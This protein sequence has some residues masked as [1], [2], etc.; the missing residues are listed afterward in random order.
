M[1]EPSSAPRTAASRGVVTPAPDQ[2]VP[3]RRRPAGSVWAPSRS[4]VD[5]VLGTEHLPLEEAD[6]GWWVPPSSDAGRVAAALD[7]GA[8]Y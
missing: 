8:R 5:L 3:A 2:H 7:A 1:A 4:R 6:D